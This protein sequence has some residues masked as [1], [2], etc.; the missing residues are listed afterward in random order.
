M[1]DYTDLYRERQDA[2]HLLKVAKI[3]LNAMNFDHVNFQSTL[4]ECTNQMAK[5]QEMTN[6][7][8]RLARIKPDCL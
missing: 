2:K 1:K 6:E 4:L 5:I 7:L 3:R 8:K